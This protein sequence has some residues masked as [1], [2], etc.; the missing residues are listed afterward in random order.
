MTLSEIRLKVMHQ[1]SRD[2]ETT[3]QVDL[4]VIPQVSQPQNNSAA[5][6]MVNS[7]LVAV[8][9]ISLVDRQRVH[10]EFCG[11]GPLIDL[12]ADE[13]ITEVIVNNR[14]EIWYEKSGHL[15]RHN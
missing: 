6:N 9:E 4:T 2:L 1:I 13:D 7:H 10:E 11:A 12:S 15:I 3:P 5:I 14:E 8:R